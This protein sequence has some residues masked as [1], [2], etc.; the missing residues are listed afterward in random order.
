MPL[1]NTPLQD[2]GYF[3]LKT[4]QI[5]QMQGKLSFLGVSLIQLK[6][7]TSGKKRRHKFLF[8]ADLLPED[9]M[10]M[11]PIPNSSPGE[12]YGLEA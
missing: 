10:Q 1:P 5:Q 6:S 9:R 8:N 2:K 3:K 12:F 7:A 11:K 4:Y